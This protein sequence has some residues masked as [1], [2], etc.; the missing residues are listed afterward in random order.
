[1]FYP[2]KFSDFGIFISPFKP[3]LAKIIQIRITYNK[4]GEIIKK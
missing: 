1:M 3:P 4:K 2:Q